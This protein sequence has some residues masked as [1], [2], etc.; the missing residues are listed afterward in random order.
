[1]HASNMVL[2]RCSQMGIKN[3]PTFNREIAAFNKQK[4]LGDKQNLEDEAKERAMYKDDTTQGLKRG[5]R[6]LITQNLIARKVS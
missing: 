6:V 4:V 2:N 1:M 5:G 3:D